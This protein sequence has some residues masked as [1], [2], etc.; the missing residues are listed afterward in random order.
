MLKRERT[1]LESVFLPLNPQQM[2]PDQNPSPPASQTFK[3]TIHHLPEAGLLPVYFIAHKPKL[4]RSFFDDFFQRSYLCFDR[5][6]A[7][8]DLLGR[9]RRRGG[10]LRGG[11]EDRDQVGNTSGFVKPSEEGSSRRVEGAVPS[12]LSGSEPPFTLQNNRQG[13]NGIPRNKRGNAKTYNQ[14]REDP[15]NH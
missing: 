2:T 8:C 3:F 14:P 6:L 1:F 5:L 7:L 12:I 9:F 13:Q 11:R 10:K 15:S 4:L